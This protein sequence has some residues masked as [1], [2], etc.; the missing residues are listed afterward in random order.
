MLLQDKTAIITGATRGIGRA[1]A[2]RFAQEGCHI[3]FCGRER[4]ERMASVEQ[5][6]QAMGVK[7]RGYA[8]DVADY[9]S[10]QEF[11]KTVLADF[12]TVDILVNNAGITDDAALK[13]MTEE[14]FDRVV[15]TN[16]KS[17]FCMTK[18]IQPSM[19]KQGHGAIVNIGSVVGIA[20]NYNQANY[21]AS[22]A[23]IIG[24]TKSCAKELA[25]RGIRCN[26]L[27]PG[28]IETDMTA[29]VPPE[30]MSTWCQRIPMKRPGTADEVAKAC[31]FLAS[32]L[33]SY[34]TSVVLPMC[35]G[36]E[37]A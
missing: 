18:A 13:R 1:I 15:G 37:D 24:F 17:V 10:A 21:A 9:Q 23:G 2:L 26:V 30:L 11:V 33:S 22:K 32:D 6:L 25:A 14:Q 27:A 12:G 34:I 8:A 29:D 7:A 35:G 20:G 19:W 31:V 4:N 28:F 5:E 16:L 36:M 3:A